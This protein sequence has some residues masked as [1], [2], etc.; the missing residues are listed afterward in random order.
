[1]IYNLFPKA[2]S[3]LSKEFIHLSKEKFENIA[4]N[5]LTYIDKDRQTE[6]L[7]DKLC[8]KLKLA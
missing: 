2:I 4:K 8:Q 7:I 5:L 6:Q 3:R 1:M